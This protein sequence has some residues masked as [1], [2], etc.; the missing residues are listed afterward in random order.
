SQTDSVDVN[1]ANS[2]GATAVMLAIRD[3]DM[4]EGMAT[5]LPWEYNPVEVVKELLKF[6]AELRGRDRNSCSALHYAANLSSPLME[7]IIPILIE[8]LRER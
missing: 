4:F 3:V 1:I 8:A 2:D 5:W 6:S 7:E